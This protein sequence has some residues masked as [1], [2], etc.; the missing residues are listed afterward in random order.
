VVS[1]LSPHLLVM[2]Q[3]TPVSGQLGGRGMGSFWVRS[4]GAVASLGVKA[5]IGREAGLGSLVGHVCFGYH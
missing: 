3:V 5:P 2:A 4:L 1:F